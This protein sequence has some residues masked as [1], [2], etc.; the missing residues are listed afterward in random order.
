MTRVRYELPAPFTHAD[1]GDLLEVLDFLRALGASL[2]LPGYA[3]LAELASELAVGE[4]AEPPARLAD[5]QII[6]LQVE[7]RSRFP[8][9]LGEVDFTR[10][11]LFR[12]TLLSEDCSKVWWPD[13]ELPSI[14][15]GP[16]HKAGASA[17][18]SAPSKKK[19]WWEMDAK[20]LVRCDLEIAVDL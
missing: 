3:S 6:L 14:V 13:P 5:L 16:S 4:G 11:A 9:H 1:A 17:A 12:Q 20:P 19:K 8:Y 10:R 15:P 7:P 2:Q 18:G